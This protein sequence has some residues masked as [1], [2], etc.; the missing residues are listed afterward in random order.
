MVL[1]KV[2]SYVIKF[3]CTTPLPVRPPGRVEYDLE[4][5]RSTLKIGFDTRFHRT[6]SGDSRIGSFKTALVIS[7]PSRWL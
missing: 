3:K 4:S 7:G 6:G 5:Q 2:E 1:E